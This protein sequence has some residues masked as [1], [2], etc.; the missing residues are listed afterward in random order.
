MITENPSSKSR[1]TRKYPLQLPQHNPLLRRR[2][3]QLRIRMPHANTRITPT[4]RPDHRA[5]TRQPRRPTR[6][7]IRRRKDRRGIDPRQDELER[8]GRSARAIRHGGEIDIE[9]DV[10]RE[11]G[12]SRRDERSGEV[13][14]EVGVDG[15]VGWGRGRP[16]G[17]GAC[18]AAEGEARDGVFGYRCCCGA[19]G[20]GQESGETEV[21]CGGREKDCYFQIRRRDDEYRTSYVGSRHRDVGRSS[22]EL[23][24]ERFDAIAH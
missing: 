4:T 13:G 17:L 1:Q 15:G 10:G 14:G 5:L 23:W 21:C 12:F 11:V 20:S 18:A 2:R 24:R 3:I 16:G 22:E 8:R 6:R 19:D 9:P 7:H